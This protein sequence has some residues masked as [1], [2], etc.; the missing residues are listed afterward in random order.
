M[1]RSVQAGGSCATRCETLTGQ[2]TSGLPFARDYCVADA[3]LAADAGRPLTSDGTQTLWRARP[4]VNVAHRT[5]AWLT[6]APIVTAVLSGST[7]PLNRGPAVARER[8]DPRQN[9]DR[10]RAA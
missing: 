1:R 10:T 7:T 3:R 9:D 5:D 2:E 6:P 4:F 8:F